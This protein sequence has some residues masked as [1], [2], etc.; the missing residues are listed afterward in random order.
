MTVD[1]VPELVTLH[2][3]GV[4]ARAVPSAMAA[5]AFGR[6]A[7]SRS[8]NSCFGIS[9]LRTVSSSATNTGC[10]GVPS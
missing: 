6:R 4:P 3:W 1:L 5:M 8:A 9:N 2:V 7:V 10:R